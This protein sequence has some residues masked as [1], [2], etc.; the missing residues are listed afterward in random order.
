MHV[1]ALVYKE[2][3]EYNSEPNLSLSSLINQYMKTGLLMEIL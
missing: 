3:E 2:K 1:L